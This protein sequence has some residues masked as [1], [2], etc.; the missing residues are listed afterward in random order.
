VK[1][2]LKNKKKKD[3]LFGVLRIAAI[4]QMEFAARENLI[5]II[6]IPIVLIVQL[7]V[8]IKNV[9]QGKMLIN[10]PMIV[11]AGLFAGT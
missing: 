10:V 3:Y 6:F 1:P 9:N 2:V 4:A 7:R 8:E 5:Q 11:G